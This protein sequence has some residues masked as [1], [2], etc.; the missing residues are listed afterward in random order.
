M[1]ELVTLNYRIRSRLIRKEGKTQAGLAKACGISTS[2]VAQWMTGAN[3]INYKHISAIAKYLDI[4]QN[5][6]KLIG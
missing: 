1:T 2:A 4:N 6:A 3:G 5:L